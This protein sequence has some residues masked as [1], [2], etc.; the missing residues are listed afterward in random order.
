MR[1]NTLKLGIACISLGLLCGCNQKKQVDYTN[2]TNQDTVELEENT[3]EEI[4]VDA[5]EGICPEILNYQIHGEQS[6]VIVI[7]KTKVPRNYS[8]CPIVEFTTSPIEDKDI[9]AYAD[10][11]FDKDSHF[12]YMPYDNEQI[13]ELK[14]KLTNIKDE[15]ED[16][17]LNAFIEEYHLPNMDLRLQNLS[18]QSDTISGEYKFYSV[19]NADINNTGG[20]TVYNGGNEYI[21][22]CGLAGTIDGEYYTMNFQRAG[23]NSC[24]LLDRMDN[25]CSVNDAGSEC[26]EVKL[27]G[28]PCTY[29]Q[30]E[31]QELAQEFV[32]KLGYDNMTV[33]QNNTAQKY[34]PNFD[35]EYYGEESTIID[36]YNIYF[37]RGYE[38]Y[39]L[40]FNSMYFEGWLSGAY[41]FDEDGNMMIGSYQNPEYIR[42][43]VDSQGVCQLELWNPWEEK[44]IIA[45]SPNMIDFEDVDEIAKNEFE[46]YTDNY[47]S[48]YTIDE[49]VLGYTVVRDGDSVTLV[50]AW[51]YY[52]DIYDETDI[53]FFKNARVIINALDGTVEHSF[54]Y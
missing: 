43:Y 25:I 52:A 29:T 49:V 18:G 10:M 48:D 45:D 3:P 26:F 53:N 20:I 31:A 51:Y 16:E 8:R 23:N 19:T 9:L 44:G 34:N 32:E 33:I 5:E 28:N 27:N 2:Q 47:I 41:V 22:A 42:V 12:L 14:N 21:D 7:A 11:I 15:T 40:A 4:P 1:K 54:R 39:S 24:L 35:L 30:E 37:A 6:D 17:E 36:G 46:N 13:A 50:P 38:D